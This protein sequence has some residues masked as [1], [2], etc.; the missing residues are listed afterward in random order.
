MPMM[1]IQLMHAS[2]REA[3]SRVAQLASKGDEVVWKPWT[4]E[5][6]RR[7]MAAPPDAF[8]ID[9]D[10]SPSHGREAALYI[11]KTAA[12]RRVPL[13]FAGGN[14]EKVEQTRALLPDAAYLAWEELPQ[15]LHGAI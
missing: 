4:P 8:V 1:R 15:G 13:I 3:P 12:L 5:F 9:L 7:L 6:Q 10:R 14:S 2:A 11:R